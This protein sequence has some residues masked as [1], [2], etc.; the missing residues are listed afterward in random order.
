[1]GGPPRRELTLTVDRPHFP[2]RSLSSLSAIRK[3]RQ[4]RDLHQISSRELT[5]YRQSSRPHPSPSSSH[6]SLTPDAGRRLNNASRR[7]LI[8]RLR[9]GRLRSTPEQTPQGRRSRLG[10][11]PAI[12]WRS[13]EPATPA[14]GLSRPLC[15]HCSA[16]RSR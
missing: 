16:E 6:T 2:A 9:R 11:G 14:L 1:M 3:A 8:L 13:P 15:L 12:S 4:C 5:S 7:L 10:L